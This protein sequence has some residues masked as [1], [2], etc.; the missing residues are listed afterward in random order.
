[1]LTGLR[2]VPSAHGRSLKMVFDKEEH[3]E[4]I[5]ALITKAAFPGEFAETVVELK[6][7]VKTA[8]VQGMVDDVQA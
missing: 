5:M 7:A 1:M 2:M 8:S 3:R 6:L 4:I